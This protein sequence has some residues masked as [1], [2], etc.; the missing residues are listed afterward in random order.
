MVYSTTYVMKEGSTITLVSHDLDGDW[1]FISA[2]PVQDI[3]KVALLVALDEVIKKDSSILD[4]SDLPSGYQAIRTNK[5]EKW[6]IHKIEYTEEDIREFGFYCA[7]C[8]EYHNEIPL[9]YGA[10]APTAYFN[11]TEEEKKRAELT[12]DL[13]IIDQK[14]FFI[15]G[16]IQI[17]VETKS[18]FFSW[19]VWIEISKNDFDAEEENWNDEN[20]FL[21]SPYPG[22]LDTPLGVYPNTLGLKV[23]VQTRQVGIMPAVF[24]T[25]SNHPL[26]LEQESGIDMKR[27]IG[28]AQE[29]LYRH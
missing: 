15:K 11:L 26:Y 16:Q 20:R 12:Q 7:K 4:V 1:Q 5:F 3:S 22:I 28:F 18:D 19:N 23:D 14:R 21:R 25:A 24:V 6:T 2:E 13:C 17:K 10:E 8:G 27:V 29:I 9:S